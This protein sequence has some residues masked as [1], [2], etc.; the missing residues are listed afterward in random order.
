MTREPSQT[1]ENPTTC[2][3]RPVPTVDS[4]DAGNGLETKRDCGIIHHAIVCDSEEPLEETL[5]DEFEENQDSLRLF[6]ETEI[7]IK[8][9]VWHHIESEKLPCNIDRS[10][11][12]K[13]TS[14][15]LARLVRYE[16]SHLQ[17]E[18]GA[19]PFKHFLQEFVPEMGR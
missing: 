7:P 5:I 18:D 4:W 17:E 11:D 16:L 1:T 10:W 12:Y 13:R 6:L 15:K 14:K 19:I 8:D 2:T 3:G 9:R